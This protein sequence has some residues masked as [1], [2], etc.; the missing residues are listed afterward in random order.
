MTML[1]SVGS[2]SS[3][4]SPEMVMQLVVQPLLDT[5]VATQVTTIVQTQSHDAR[6]PIVVADPTTAF[7]AEGEEITPSESDLDEIVVT[8]S[9]CAGLTI[10]SNE[11]VADSDPSALE[12]VGSG[13]VRDLQTRI[14][15]SFFGNTT[16]NGPDGLLSLLNVQD[17]DAG[18]AIT[19]LDPF[20]EAITK[21]ENVGG[22][23]TAFCANPA[24][25]LDLLQL[26]I[27]ADNIQPL[28]GV[29]ASSPTKRSVFGVPLFSSP[30]IGTDVVWAIPKVKCFSVI[31]LPATVVTDSSAYFSSDRTGVRSTVRI[32]YGFPH[33]EAIVKIGIG[34]S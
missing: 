16:A 25:V 34:G 19:N 2:G 17:V 26:K 9:K 23:V 32:G 24:V 4:L 20:A 21:C 15:A 8:P 18:S 10:I 28:L 13:L 14:D 7:T 11:L 30:A 1:T 5:A 3:I 6:F 12:V 31:R 22:T 33:Q 27:Q 29:D